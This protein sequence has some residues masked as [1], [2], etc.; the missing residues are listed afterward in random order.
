MDEA[1][2]S[3]Q[4]L[5]KYPLLEALLSAEGL[6]LK[7]KWTITDVAQIFGVGNRAIYD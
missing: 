3:N 4:A 5:G 6:P 1:E 2:G 7:G